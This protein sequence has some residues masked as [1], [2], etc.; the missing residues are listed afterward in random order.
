[1]AH[2]KRLMPPPRGAYYPWMQPRDRAIVVGV[3]VAFTAAAPVRA[4]APPVRAA[5]PGWVIDRWSSEQGLPQNTVTGIVQAADGYLWLGTYGGLVRFDGLQFTAFTTG[6]HPGLGSDR[7]IHIRV[8]RDGTMWLGTDRGLVRFRDGAFHEWTDTDGRPAGSTN[9]MF[10]DEAGGVWV[11]TE[12]GVGDRRDALDPRRVSDRAR[13]ELRVVPVREPAGAAVHHRVPGVE[14]QRQQ[15]GHRAVG[16]HVGQ[17][18]R[19]VSARDW[20][21][22][23]AVRGAHQGKRHERKVLVLA[24]RQRQEVVSERG[25]GWRA[26]GRAKRAGHEWSARLA[27]HASRGDQS[28]V[29]DRCNR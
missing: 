2:D 18:S 17:R 15:L 25:A 29:C 12:E 23:R 10:L 16:L 3:V 26:P 9:S 4:Q 27:P 5:T 6:G 21:H 20:N 7:V 8:A 1:L 13:L 14:L 22:A 11:S 28:T 24:L 19:L